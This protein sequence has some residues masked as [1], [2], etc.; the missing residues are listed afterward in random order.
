MGPNAP[1]DRLHLMR[2]Y[3]K[4]SD[5]ELAINDRPSA[6]RHT[7]SALQFFDEFKI[8]SPSLL[9]LRDLGFCYESLGNLQ[10]SLAT[11]R[12][13]SLAERHTA[14]AVARQWYGK[15]A[16]VWNEWFRR[17]AA[18]PDSEVERYKVDH[19]LQGK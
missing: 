13:F 17:G 5:A 1:T 11:D 9:V 4:L 7:N 19:L 8:T 3:C 6:M 2:S 14:G 16:D 18:T 12:A 10:R 15:S